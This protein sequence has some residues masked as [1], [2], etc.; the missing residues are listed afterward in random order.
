MHTPIHLE[1]TLRGYTLLLTAAR[2][3]GNGDVYAGNGITGALGSSTL[4]FLARL[5]ITPATMRRTARL[6]A[7]LDSVRQRLACLEL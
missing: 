3:L 4:D 1:E 2:R 6:I 7:M 5:R